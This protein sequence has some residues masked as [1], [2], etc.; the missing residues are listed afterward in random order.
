MDNSSETTGVE[1]GTGLSYRHPVNA[2]DIDVKEAAKARTCPKIPP[3]PSNGPG[4]GTLITKVLLVLIGTVT[5]AWWLLLPKLLVGFF[6]FNIFRGAAESACS[7]PGATYIPI[8]QNAG[9]AKSFDSLVNLQSRLVDVQE[10]GAGG[11]TIPMQLEYSK[12]I[13]RE[14]ASIVR[15]SKIPSR[16]VCLQIALLASSSLYLQRQSRQPFDRV[17]A[18]YRYH[19]R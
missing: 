7:L 11:R 8:C 19:E 13:V 10:L 4:L 18:A 9:G 2:N 12:N 3:K 1:V 14:V 5:G 16:F 17:L 6:L 15:Q